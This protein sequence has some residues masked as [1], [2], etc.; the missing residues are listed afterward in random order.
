VVEPA[1]FKDFMIWRL[2]FTF[3]HWSQLPPPLQDA[4][5]RSLRML[6]LWRGPAF[7]LKLVQGTGDADL[8]RRAQIIL[9]GP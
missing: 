7:A 9:Y 2:E 5:L 4:A 8:T 1:G 3:S 6:S